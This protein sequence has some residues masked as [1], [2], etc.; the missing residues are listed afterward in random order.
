MRS[1]SIILLSW[2]SIT[3]RQ[4][5][6][7]LYSSSA[8]SAPPSFLITTI[9]PGLCLSPGGLCY[10]QIANEMAD[11]CYNLTSVLEG[12][13]AVHTMLGPPP[14]LPSY[15]NTSWYLN[16][17]SSN[18]F[19]PRAVGFHLNKQLEVVKAWLKWSFTI[20]KLPS[21]IGLPLI[22]QENNRMVKSDCWY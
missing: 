3:S 20:V 15:V 1:E 9:V 17:T 7:F 2:Y 21:S 10:L 16:S 11:P 8:S 18:Y 12:Q 4:N 22:T 6:F 5:Q 19:P 13:P 14:N